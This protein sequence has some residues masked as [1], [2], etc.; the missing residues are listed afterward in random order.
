MIHAYPQAM[1]QVPR[2]TPPAA[3]WQQY[4]AVR[5]DQARR[6]QV[7]AAYEAQMAAE[8]AAQLQA[9]GGRDWLCERCGV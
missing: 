4:K 5:A 1:Q 9:Q 3:Q 2:Q 8:R 7:A 6:N